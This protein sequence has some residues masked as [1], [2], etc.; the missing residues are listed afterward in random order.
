MI[1]IEAYGAFVR[2][3]RGRQGLV[4]ISNICHR[5]IAHPAEILKEGD[6]VEAKVLHIQRGGKRISLGIKQV[7]V[8][9]WAGA[10]ERLPERSLVRGVIERILE[11]GV[12]I[13]LEGDLSGF[14]PRS[15]CGFAGERSLATHFTEG[16]PV[17]V[18]V[19][20]LDTRAQR[21]L[22]S[23]LH[24]DGSRIAAEEASFSEDAASML[25]EETERP[26]AGTD[27]GELLRRALSQK[28]DCA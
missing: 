9:P 19:V 8:D 4:H 5:R 3:G 7:G 28:T 20:S 15:E 23:F 14:V 13:A 17:S 21:L 18:R 6:A 16:E 27:L 2:F 22:L 25:S 12:I 10:E 1:R 26:P 24:T 11:A